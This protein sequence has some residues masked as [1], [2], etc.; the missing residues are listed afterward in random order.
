MID[1]QLACVQAQPA[2]AALTGPQRRGADA[3]LVGPQLVVER[4]QVGGEVGGGRRALGRDRR[5]LGL[6]LGRLAVAG[7]EQRRALLTGGLRLLAEVGELGLGL[8]EPL[9]DLDLLLLEG[10]DAAFEGDQLLLHPL[11]VLGVGHQ[12]LVHPVAVAR[13]PGLDDLDVGVDLLLLGGEVLDAGARV[14]REVVEVL[15]LGPRGLQVGV[16][17]HGGESMTE[18]VGARVELLDVEQLQLGFRV[19]FQRVLLDVTLDAG[20]PRVGDDPAHASL[21]RISQRL[22][23]PRPHHRQ[24]RPLGRPVRDVDQRGP[25]LLEELRGRGG[26]AG[27]W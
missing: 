2:A 16:L 11:Q 26:A 25:A 5:Q 10:V 3:V 27:R 8:L 20:V 22:G 9:H 13:A 15:H 1:G 4:E 24:P 18:L 17:G 19:G 7:G 12:P 23:Q 21:H 14:D 6:D